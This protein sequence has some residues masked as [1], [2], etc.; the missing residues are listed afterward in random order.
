MQLRE[1]TL[2]LQEILRQGN[3]NVDV[4]INDQ[5][6]PDPGYNANFEVVYTPQTDETG[7]ATVV[8]NVID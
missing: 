5:Q 4:R 2:T 1:L 7:P 3:A 8:F 6:Y